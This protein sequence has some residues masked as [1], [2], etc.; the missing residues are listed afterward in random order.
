LRIRVK[1]RENNIHGI[2]LY[3]SVED[4]FGRTIRVG[5]THPAYSDGYEKIKYITKYGP[6][7]E[8]L[9]SAF[10]DHNFEQYKH[11]VGRLI[12]IYEPDEDQWLGWDYVN[13]SDNYKGI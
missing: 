12:V 4:E 1:L 10:K 11:R 13:D 2:P 5:D 8:S 7:I 6:G 3:S 9:S